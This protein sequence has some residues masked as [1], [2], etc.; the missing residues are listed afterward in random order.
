MDHTHYLRRWWTCVS[1]DLP[2]S[3][4]PTEGREGPSSSS[5]LCKFI[6][7]ERF[8]VAHLQIAWP[9]KCKLCP[10]W[11]RLLSYVSLFGLPRSDLVHLGVN[12][13]RL[14]KNW[15]QGGSTFFFYQLQNMLQAGSP[16]PWLMQ[17]VCLLSGVWVTP[18]QT[19]GRVV[20]RH[21]NSRPRC[22]PADSE[23]LWF[24]MR[25]PTVSL[26]NV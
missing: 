16:P 3:S 1:L 17:G 4:W 24:D 20:A 8:I 11:D 15:R 6:L 21:L 2:L 13:V 23:G 19:K 10:C 12:T 14:L 22:P 25:Q 26:L 5:S 7:R 18:Q 9:F